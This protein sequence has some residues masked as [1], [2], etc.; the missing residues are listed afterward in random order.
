MIHAN[1]LNIEVSEIS[2]EFAQF[3]NFQ[4]DVITNQGDIMQGGFAI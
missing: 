2:N 4:I 3:L 1:Y